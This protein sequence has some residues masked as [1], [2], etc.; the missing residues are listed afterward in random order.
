MTGSTLDS[1]L[2]WDANARTVVVPL[3]I[4]L[5]EL[6]MKLSCAKWTYVGSFGIEGVR[7]LGV[8]FCHF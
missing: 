8:R 1:G 6:I 4:A 5:R 2:S 7:T 3:A